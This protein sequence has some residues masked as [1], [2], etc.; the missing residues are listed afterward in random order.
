[1]RGIKEYLK[2]SD[3]NEC[4]KVLMSI[5]FE[6]NKVTGSTGDQATEP[7]ETDARNETKS[8]TPMEANTYRLE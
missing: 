8:S 2:N 5:F 3:C 6:E 4:K 1:M 7:A